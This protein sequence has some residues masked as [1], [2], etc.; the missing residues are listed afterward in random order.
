[1][2]VGR[3]RGSRLTRAASL[4]VSN[5]AGLAIPCPMDNSHDSRARVGAHFD[6][7]VQLAKRRVNEAR[8]RVH[9]ARHATLLG[10]FVATR[11]RR[12]RRRLA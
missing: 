4:N 3:E 11:S 12:D 8:W 5:P 1:M 2:S 9:K 6:Q 10:G 7:A